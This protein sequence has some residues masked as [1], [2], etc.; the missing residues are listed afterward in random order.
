MGTEALN[1]LNEKSHKIDTG[2]YWSKHKFIR[3]SFLTLKRALPNMFW[4]LDNDKNQK[5][6]MA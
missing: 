4:Y 6:Q 1:L 5:R 2:R 3:R